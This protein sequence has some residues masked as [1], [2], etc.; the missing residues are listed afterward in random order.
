V[1]EGHYGLSMG[2][3]V[4]IARRRSMA[5]AAFSFADRDICL[6]GRSP[7]ESQPKPAPR[8]TNWTAHWVWRYPSSF[9]VT[10]ENRLAAASP[11]PG[12]GAVNKFAAP[13]TLLCFTSK[14][15][16]GDRSH[17]D[18]PGRSVVGESQV[19]YPNACSKEA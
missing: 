5:C 8:P 2:I 18:T 10:D 17:G 9:T 14:Q 11:A 6:L 13:A 4:S 19:T 1:P 12:S 7:P 16:D 3:Y 15:L